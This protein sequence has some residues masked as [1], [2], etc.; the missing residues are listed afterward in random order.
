M[1]KR[2]LL[3]G[4]QNE[5]PIFIAVEFKDEKVSVFLYVFSKEEVQLKTLQDWVKSGN[6]LPKPLQ[7]LER[8]IQDENLLP[9]DIKVVQVGKVRDIEI[10][11]S[12]NLM[13]TRM[14]QGFD[15][16]LLLLKDKLSS[17]DDY[18]Q[19][20]FDECGD[21]WN[22][23][24]TFKQENN[25]I[26]NKI[27]DNYKFELDILFEALKSLRKDFKKEQNAKALEAKADLLLKLELI[28]NKLNDK[29]NYKSL[30]ERLKEVR[31]GLIKS[32]LR[33]N[34]YTE[35]DDKINALFDKM[36]NAKATVNAGKFD[37][38]IT[39]LE[40]IVTKMKKSLDWDKRE[41]SKEENNKKYAEQ[42]FQI[43]LIDAKIELINVKVKEKEDKIKDINSTLATLK[44]KAGK[45]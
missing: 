39:D 44:K 26:D 6:K 43:Q 10:A 38:R 12:D 16:E 13:Q 42:V 25:G 19:E 40:A 7:S 27:I 22:R 1:R 45:M 2:F 31:A 33:Q 15:G 34:H 17:L 8:T 11:W 14:L 21:F 37:K 18:S 29:P 35:I 24:L 3:E 28:E 36:G 30:I 4:E 32:G 20:L 5:Q 41:L 9:E 23:V